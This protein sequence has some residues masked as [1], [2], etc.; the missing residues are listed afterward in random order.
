MKPDKVPQKVMLIQSNNEKSWGYLY[1]SGVPGEER[2]QD[3]LND[4]RKFLPFYGISMSKSRNA[5]DFNKMTLINKNCIMKIDEVDEPPIAA[6][7]NGN[8]SAS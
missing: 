8:P 4:D 3:L 1:L 5:A 7:G 6:Q 2:L